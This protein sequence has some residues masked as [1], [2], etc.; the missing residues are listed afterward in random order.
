MG[1]GFLVL[2]ATR[3]FS[4]G[5]ADS[6]C[7]KGLDGGALG[8]NTEKGENEKTKFP[9]S[10]KRKMGKLRNLELEK[11]DAWGPYLKAKARGGTCDPV[12]AGTTQGEKGKR[13]RTGPA[14]HAL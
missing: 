1:G 6:G 7:K 14:S 12:F 11:R 13:G 5:G 4:E 2:R 8:F 10:Q 9:G 3:L